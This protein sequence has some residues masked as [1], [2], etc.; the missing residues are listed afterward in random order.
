MSKR[1]SLCLP[2]GFRLRLIQD[3]RDVWRDV[4]VH[5]LVQHK[6]RVLQQLG[7]RGTVVDLLM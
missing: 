2:V 7:I 1:L 4:R 3:L 5:V 6:E